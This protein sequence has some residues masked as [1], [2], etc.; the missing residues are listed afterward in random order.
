MRMVP[1]GAARV[2]RGQ[3]DLDVVAF[4]R[5]HQPHDVVG[6]AARAAVRAVEMQVRVVEL[7]RI[8]GDGGREIAVG[9]QVVDEPDLQGLTRLHA[10]RRGKP[11]F[12][13]AQVEAKA[14]DVAIGI[15]TTQAGAQL[16]VRRAAGLRLDQRL[17]H[18]RRNR[19]VRHTEFGHVGVR[20]AALSQRSALAQ[21]QRADRQTGLQ[22]AAP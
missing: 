2:I 9:R 19:Q 5:L 15:G 3:R 16:S 13:A 12:V 14:A 17:I 21:C 7:V 10:Q 18:R 4:S 11:A 22:Q 1:V 6:D 20:A 8:R